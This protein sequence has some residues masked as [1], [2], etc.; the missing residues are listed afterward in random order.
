[1]K[2]STDTEFI[3]APDDLTTDQQEAFRRAI[4]NDATFVWGP[5]GTGKTVTLSAIAFYLFSLNKRILLVSHTNRAVDGIVFSLC[6][7]IV[8]KARVNLPE[9][10][11]VRIGQMSRKRLRERSVPRYRLSS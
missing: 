6:K 9:G 4:R 1:M 11:I 10:S 8:G 3:G 2:P 7:R 5:P